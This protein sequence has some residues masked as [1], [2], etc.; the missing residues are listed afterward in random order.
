LA[1]ISIYG[2]RVK[3]TPTLSSDIAA[4]AGTKD[5]VAGGSWDTTTPAN[6]VL[7]LSMNMEKLVCNDARAY[8]CELSYKSSATGGVV[9]VKSNETLAVYGTYNEECASGGLLSIDTFSSMIMS[10]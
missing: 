9:A 4:V 1:N 3:W 2:T 6:T 5:F 7:T 8:R 10:A